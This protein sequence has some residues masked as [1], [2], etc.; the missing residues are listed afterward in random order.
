MFEIQI[1]LA[2]KNKSVIGECEQ[3]H[4]F[5]TASGIFRNGHDNIKIMKH[6]AH[7]DRH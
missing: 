4:Y 5:R 6:V 3:N 7:F 2:D 1:E